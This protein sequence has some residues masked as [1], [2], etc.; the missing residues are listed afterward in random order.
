MSLIALKAQRAGFG[1]D[2]VERQIMR[3]WAN[4]GHA[5]ELEADADGPRAGNPRRQRAVEIAAAVAEPVAGGIKATSGSKT[6]S[7]AMSAAIFGAMAASPVVAATGMGMPWRSVV[8]GVVGVQARKVI[9]AAG[10]RPPASRR[11]SL[12]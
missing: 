8:I 10:R 7:G 5:G 3:L 12:R 6:M 2:G 9:G 4:V 11:A 1:D